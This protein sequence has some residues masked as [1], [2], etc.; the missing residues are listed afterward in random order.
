MTVGDIYQLKLQSVHP[1]G[2]ECLNV[3]YY[4]IISQD[5]ELTAENVADEFQDDIMLVAIQPCVET[6]IFNRLTTIN[7]MDNLDNNETNPAA[8]GQGSTDTPAASNQAVAMRS[9]RNGPGTRYSYKRWTGYPHTALGTSDG[10]FNETYFDGLSP[11]QLILSENIVHSN[12]ELAPIQIGGGFVLGISPTRNFFLTDP[13]D[14]GR[15]PSHQDTRQHFLWDVP[16]P[17]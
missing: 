10:S 14:V 9:Q 1:V 3:F 15:F 17:A 13:W 4:E 8:I 12:G 7:G 5:G 2:E 11:A 6:I 16:T